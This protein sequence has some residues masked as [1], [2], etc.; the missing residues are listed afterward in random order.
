VALGHRF[1]GPECLKPS[2]G[3]GG[4]SG[5]TPGHSG[6]GNGTPRARIRPVAKKRVLTPLASATRK[7]GG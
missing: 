6:P 1:R 2:T 3:I 7:S 4:R 5:L